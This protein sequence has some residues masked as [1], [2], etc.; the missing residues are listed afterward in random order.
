MSSFCVE[1]SNGLCLQCIATHHH[2]SHRCDVTLNLSGLDLGEKAIAWEHHRKD[3]LGFLSYIFYLAV[4]GTVWAW[5]GATLHCYMVI[6]KKSHLLEIADDVFLTARTSLVS[7]GQRWLKGPPLW[8]RNRVR[9]CWTDRK[10]ASYQPLLVPGSQFR[11]CPSVSFE[12]FEKQKRVF[13][14]VWLQ[15]HE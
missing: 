7:D 3:V 1:I 9:L 4:E 10:T 8:E 13:S 5:T 15:L 11:S 6:N 12:P 14:W 2:L